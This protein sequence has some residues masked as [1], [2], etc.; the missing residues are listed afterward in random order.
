MGMGQGL[1]P[2]ALQMA[3]MLQSLEGVNGYRTF[4]ACG[5]KAQNCSQA[6]LIY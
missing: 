5:L 6:L 2:K 1:L 3:A 4:C